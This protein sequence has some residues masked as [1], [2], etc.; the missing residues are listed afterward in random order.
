[1]FNLGSV[2]MHLNWETLTCNEAKPKAY[3]ALRPESSGVRALV[4]AKGEAINGPFK[5]LPVEKA[6]VSL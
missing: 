5:L 3:I 4:H 2:D 1:M 6:S